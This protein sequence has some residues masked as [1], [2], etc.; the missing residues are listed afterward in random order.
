MF[1]CGPESRF[2]RRLAHLE[3]TDESLGEAVKGTTLHL[4]V[5]EVK[6]APKH[7]HAQQGEDD[8]EEEKQQEQGDDGA[9]RV[10]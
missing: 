6:L 4:L 2:C 10:Q 7:L 9:H 1:L 8:N 3:N 5:G